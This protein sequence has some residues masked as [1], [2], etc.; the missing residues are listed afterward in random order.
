ML[1]TQ[2]KPKKRKSA[3]IIALLVALVCIALFVSPYIKEYTSKTSKSGQLIT[4]TIPEGAG[5]AQIAQMLEDKDL[6]KSKYTFLLKYHLNRDLYQSIYPGEFQL[7]KGMCLD[8]IL[9]KLT[10]QYLAKEIVTLTIPEGFTV[11]MI[12]LRCQN[13]GLCSKE[14]F[15]S[16]VDNGEYDYEFIKHIPD[17][18]YTHKLE[19]FLF[20]D[21]YEFYTDSAPS[22]IVDRMLQAF[23]NA[24]LSEFST[25]DNMFDNIIIASMIEREAAIDSER[26]TISGV[27]KN[28]LALPMRLQ[29]DATAVYAKTNGYYDIET[30]TGEDVQFNS[31]YNTY[32]CDGLPPGPICCPGIKSIVA[33][34]NPQNHSY[35]YYHTDTTKGDG[36]HIFTENYGDH[37]ATMR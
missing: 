35:Y 27:I 1:E 2:N 10:T 15:V 8:D 26:S 4:I 19:G 5:A 17:G 12:A 13:L 25:Y 37:N 33:A 29:L 32:I 34:A 16:A 23:E 22:E 3:V 9:K 18:N 30:P 7:H 24:Y 14:E 20:P 11:E 36:S 21:T 31:P 28:R 6:I